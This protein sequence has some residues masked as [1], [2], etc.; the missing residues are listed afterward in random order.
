[1]NAVVTTLLQG[2]EVSVINELAP[3]VVG[4]FPQG[5]LLGGIEVQLTVEEIYSDSVEVTQH[6][7]ESGADI[8]D[9]AFKR[10]MELVL[11]SGWSN[12]SDLSLLN[13]PSQATF[14]GGSMVN[15]DYISGVYSALL[16]L[17]E[18]RQP[19]VVVSGLRRYDA[20]VITDLEVRRD[21][22]TANALMLVAYCKQIIYASAQATVMTPQANQA[23]PASTAQT[24]SVGVLAPTVGKPAPGG[25]LPPSQ[26]GA[27]VPTLQL[28]TLK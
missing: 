4:L 26:W 20:M 11:R 14:T 22:T 1:M 13:L 16:A 24:Q 23:N 3:S 7:V 12:S 18:S 17:Q 6:P 9:H 8:S 28:P 10:P 2:A 27:N 21:T 5:N 25:S 15:A 19:L